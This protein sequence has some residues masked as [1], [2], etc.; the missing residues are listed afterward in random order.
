LTWDGYDEAVSILEE[1]L[2]EIRNIVHSSRHF[3]DL[4]PDVSGY[5][6]HA[7]ECYVSSNEEA[8]LKL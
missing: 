3:E 8:F 5:V 7:V 4:Y 1:S 6:E 2:H